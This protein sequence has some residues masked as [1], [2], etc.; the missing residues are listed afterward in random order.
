MR[1]TGCRRALRFR[2]LAVTGE[3]SGER[4]L[5]ITAPE[6]LRHAGGTMEVGSTVPGK[7]TA[8][9]FGKDNTLT[10]EFAD[11]PAGE[12]PAALLV[13]DKAGAAGP[14]RYLT[15]LAKS[16]TDETVQ[17]LFPRDDWQANLC[18]EVALKGDGRWHKYRLDIETRMKNTGGFTFDRQR[19]ELFLYYRSMRL[20]DIHRPAMKFELKE[21]ILE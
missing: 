19:G 10:V 21:V 5:N 8:A 14:Y 3:K 11:S 18:G 16:A 1:S 20:P 17:F 15:F 12:V 9:D 6:R 4:L 13:Y 2:Y 7:V